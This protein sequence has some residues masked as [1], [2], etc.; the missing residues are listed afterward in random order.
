MNLNKFNISFTFLP[1]S[2]L[3]NFSSLQVTNSSLGS[4]VAHF[5]KHCVKLKRISEKR[6][7]I[8]DLVCL[9]ELKVRHSCDRL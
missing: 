1:N 5:E 3:N 6:Y 4:Q 7:K 8:K 9:N 2:S